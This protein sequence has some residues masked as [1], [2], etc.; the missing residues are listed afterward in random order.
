MIVTLP[1]NEQWEEAVVW[2]KRN[3]PSYITNDT[4]RIIILDIVSM[5]PYRTVVNYYFGDEKDAVMF[6][7][8]WA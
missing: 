1:F 2:A 6:Q 5:Y 4:S 7:L 3:C 8:R